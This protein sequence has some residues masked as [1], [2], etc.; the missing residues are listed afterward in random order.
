M[1][2]YTAGELSGAVD[3]LDLEDAPLRMALSP[4][5]LVLALGN[6]GLQQFSIELRP[7]LPPL[8]TPASGQAACL[9]ARH[10]SAEQEH[11]SLVRFLAAPPS[12]M[13]HF[14]GLLCQL[15]LCNCSCMP[16]TA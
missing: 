15:S 1:I 16:G 10:M 8:L 2:Q 11:A 3:S 5:A 12:N 14:S 7:K 4:L 9:H 13:T 6:G